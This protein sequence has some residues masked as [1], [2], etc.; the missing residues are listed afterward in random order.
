MIR[1]PLLIA[2]Y[3][4]IAL[5]LLS[6]L[7]SAR[8]IHMATTGADTADCGDKG[9]PCLSLAGTLAVA[10]NGDTIRIGIGEFETHDVLIEKDVIIQ[11]HG[12]EHST[13]SGS[14]KG[15]VL[16]IAKGATVTIQDVS[17][18]D[19]RI[20][21][22]PGESADGGSIY[23]EGTLTLRRVTVRNNTAT[24]FAGTAGTHGADRKDRKGTATAGI[25]VECKRKDLETTKCDAFDTYG[26][27]GQK[28]IDGGRGT[29]GTPGG[30]AR[31]GA[32]FN[33]GRLTVENST[34]LNNTA[35]GGAGGAGG[36]GG[37]GGAG[38]KGGSGSYLRVK[39]VVPVCKASF[40]GRGGHGGS[41]GRAGKGGD[42][43]NA[44]GGGIYSE[45][46]AQLH[47]INS[48]VLNNVALPGKGWRGRYRWQRGRGGGQRQQG[49]PS[50]TVRRSDKAQV[51]ACQ[52]GHRWPTRT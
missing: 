43:G 14:E 12:A 52:R 1:L 44:H 6:S 36:N 35:T 30:H 51:L 33:A 4:A 50:E 8:D 34:L 20:V 23:N 24:G 7:A 45:V 17:L 31:G 16:R 47:V 38:Q 48:K 46:G 26:K 49:Y 39:A 15:R 42:S 21:A 10:A 3:A 18:S 25:K 13:L 22:G 19:G 40:G 37:N 28:G 11:G 41:G 9:T 2:P 27:D 32:I 5:V 29:D